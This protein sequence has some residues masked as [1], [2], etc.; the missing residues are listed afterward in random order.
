MVGMHVMILSKH[1]VPIGT[2][3]ALHMSIG[4][5][6]L[7]GGRASLSRSPEAVAALLAAC[8]PRFPKGIEDNQYHL[9]PL[10]H[11]WVLAVS[12]RGLRTVDVESGRDVMVPVGLEL[13]SH[14]DYDIPV[15]RTSSAPQKFIAPCLLPPLD[16]ILALYVKS[17]YY[18]PVELLPAQRKGHVIS[19]KRLCL[20]VQRRSCLS[21]LGDEIGNSDNHGILQARNP[22]PPWACLGS[23]KSMVAYS[24]SYMNDPVLCTFSRYFCRRVVSDTQTQVWLGAMPISR[25]DCAP[26]SIVRWCTR[27]LNECISS[28]N[29]IALPMYM[30]MHHSALTL[31]SSWHSSQAWSLCV[32]LR[33]FSKQPLRKLLRSRINQEFIAAVRVHVG[34]IM[35][36]RSKSH[37]AVEG[38]WLDE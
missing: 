18:H 17:E 26:L 9:Q 33:Y 31:D 3:M 32:A 13:G 6:F 21:S 38:S 12:W 15:L 29:V 14:I 2:H 10:R 28:D 36:T 5:L 24:R 30:Q 25:F 27:V 22:S 19:L 1:S 37:G 4:L 35:L 7:G 20:F 8:F 34:H 23:S 11:L 16:D